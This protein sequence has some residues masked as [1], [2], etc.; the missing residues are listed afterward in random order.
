MLIKQKKKI[1]IVRKSLQITQIFSRKIQIPL[2]TMLKRGLKVQR[3]QKNRNMKIR[4]MKNMTIKPMMKENMIRLTFPI[5][6]TMKHMSLKEL[7]Q[8][9]SFPILMTSQNL[10]SFRRRAWAI[11]LALSSLTSEQDMKHRQ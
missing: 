6:G 10:H 4:R 7:S 1:L 9:Q 2:K 8:I 3:L 5:Q 11:R